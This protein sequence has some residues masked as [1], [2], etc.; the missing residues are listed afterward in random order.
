[1][2]RRSRRSSTVLQ[3][4]TA[5]EVH[6]TLQF[7]SLRG[8]G[9]AVHSDAAFQGLCHAAATAAALSVPRAGGIGR[10][11]QALRSARLESE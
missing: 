7:L 5:R 4:A 10:A 6:P 3:R 2:H 9:L 8:N 11:S 1:M